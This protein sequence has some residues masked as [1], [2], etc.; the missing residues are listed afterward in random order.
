[1]D[2]FPAFRFVLGRNYD[3]WIRQLIE[4]PE[5]FLKCINMSAH[6]SDADRLKFRRLV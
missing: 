6:S 3:A 4:T 5:G 2:L 1:M